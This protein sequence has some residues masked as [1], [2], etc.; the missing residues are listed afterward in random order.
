MNEFNNRG[1]YITESLNNSID[2]DKRFRIR[3]IIFCVIELVSLL[4]C[5]NH[6]DNTILHIVFGSL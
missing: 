3:R 4:F 1:T 2:D 6:I 5:E